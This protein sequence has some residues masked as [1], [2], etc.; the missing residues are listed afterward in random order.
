MDSLKQFESLPTPHDDDSTWRTI[1]ILLCFTLSFVLRFCGDHRPHKKLNTEWTESVYIQVL[2][3][4]AT[5]TFNSVLK[6][7]SL[8]NMKKQ[9][10]IICATSNY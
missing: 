8:Q 3:M 5:N 2:V 9:N 1:I 4:C 7:H 10:D 6:C